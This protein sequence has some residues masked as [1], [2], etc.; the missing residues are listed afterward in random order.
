M[1]GSVVV[2]VWVEGKCPPAVGCIVVGVHVVVRGI[3]WLEVP[4]DT[5][6]AWQQRLKL[7]VLRAKHIVR[8]QIRA[9]FHIRDGVPLSWK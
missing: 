3:A 4:M 1:V 9:Q 6:Q 7:Q 2:S 5:L 8:E